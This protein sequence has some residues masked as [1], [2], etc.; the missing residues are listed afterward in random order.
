MAATGE[1]AAAT[2]TGEPRVDGGASVVGLASTLFRSA[3]DIVTHTLEIA[4]LESRL[5]GSALVWIVGVGVAVLLLLV[6]TWGLLLAA[7]IRALMDLGLSVGASLLLGALVNLAVAVLL[8]LW[9]LRL[10]RR[11][12]FAATRRMLAKLRTDAGSNA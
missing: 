2:A 7:G 8:V 10:A 11:M 12:T 3:R 1:T 5:A 6:S 9:V 4:V